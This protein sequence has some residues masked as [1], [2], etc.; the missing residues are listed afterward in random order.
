M[1]ALGGLGTGQSLAI[2]GLVGTLGAAI[3]VSIGQAVGIGRA[4]DA[5]GPGAV[6]GGYR[7]YRARAAARPARY[8]GG[9]N[10]RYARRVGYAADAGYIGLGKSWAAERQPEQGGTK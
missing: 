5:S 10:T 4:R 7:G 8:S 9:R 6:F 1:Q 3:Y 2:A